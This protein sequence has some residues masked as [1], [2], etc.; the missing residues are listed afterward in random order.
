MGRPNMLCKHG[1]DEG[2]FGIE[3]VCQGQREQQLVLKMVKHGWSPETH[4][5][6]PEA[7]RRFVKTVLLVCV[8]LQRPGAALPSMPRELWHS[9]LS[10]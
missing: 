6:Y 1:G 5:L 2:R 10:F 3:H 8:C 9:I 7:A 4:K